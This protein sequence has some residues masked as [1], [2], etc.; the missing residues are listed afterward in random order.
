[1]EKGRADIEFSR[2]N[3]LLKLNNSLRGEVSNL[4]IQVSTAKSSKSRLAKELDEKEAKKENSKK[5]L[6]DAIQE[7]EERTDYEFDETDES[8]EE[9]IASVIPKLLEDIEALKVENEE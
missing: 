8:M 1:M 7:I 3:N 6:D 9:F 5:I 4:K 2:A